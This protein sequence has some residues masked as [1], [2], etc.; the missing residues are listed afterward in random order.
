M[1]RQYDIARESALVKQL[2]GGLC[3]GIV[4]I[5]CE[6]HLVAIDNNGI[7]RRNPERGSHSRAYKLQNLSAQ[8]RV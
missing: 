2:G 3:G 1:K 6:I 5:L 8:R 7:Q 4:L